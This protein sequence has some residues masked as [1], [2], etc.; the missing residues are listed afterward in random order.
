MG[1]WNDC[2]DDQL[3]GVAMNQAMNQVA[4]TYLA[5]PVAVG[6]REVV[7]VGDNYVAATG[8]THRRN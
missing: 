7:F 2:R 3:V 1:L 6:N 8:P 4:N 5:I